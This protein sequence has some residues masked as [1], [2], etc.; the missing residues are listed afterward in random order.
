MSRNIV[1]NPDGA[2]RAGASRPSG[3]NTEFCDRDVRGGQ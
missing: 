3:P 2:K 1:L